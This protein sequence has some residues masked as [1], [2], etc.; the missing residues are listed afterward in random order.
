MQIIKSLGKRKPKDTSS[1]LA[2][3]VLA[4]CPM[5]STEFETQ[6]RQI[7]HNNL[8][9]CGCSK[10]NPLHLITTKNLRVQQ[11]RLYRIWKNIR[12]RCTN[13]K[14]NNAKDYSLRGIALDP[15][16]DN[17]ENFF[18]WSIKA[19]YANHLSIDRI[20][21]NGNYTPSNCRWATKQEQMKN[22]RLLRINN[23]SG[24]RGVN[25]K[26]NKFSARVHDG[27]QRVY[28]GAFDTVEQAAK[29]YDTYVKKNSLGF[30]LNF[31]SYK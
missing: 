12:T 24:Y 15:V 13:K 2:E 31:E 19:G 6:L 4:K 26:G 18:N 16:W 27:K 23:T 30:P 11:P 25:R 21:V 9:S 29:A 5:C 3:Y 17:F 7:K 10:K 1:Y 8:K 14:I 20:D 22:T 28:L